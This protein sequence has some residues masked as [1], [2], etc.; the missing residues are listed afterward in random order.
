MGGTGASVQDAAHISPGGEWRTSKTW[1]PS[2]STKQVL[3]L[4]AER[5]IEEK[6]QASAKP[7][8]YTFDPEHPNPTLGGRQGPTCIVNQLVNRPDV[9][10]F[11]GSPLAKPVDATGPVVVRLSISSDRPSADFTARLIDVYPEGYA[12]NLAEGQVR[13]R[14][15]RPG[16]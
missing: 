12:M 4:T 11:T 6:P 13:V 1:P 7:L 16:K 10:S 9:I 8:T 14:G 15:L 3:H 2:G 5:T